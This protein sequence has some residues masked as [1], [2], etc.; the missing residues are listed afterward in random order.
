[1]PMQPPMTQES[2]SSPTKHQAP[3]C[4]FCGRELARVTRGQYGFWAPCDCPDAQ[5]HDKV[6][7]AE[8]ERAIAAE[9]EEAR[10][11]R[12]RKA[13]IP[14]RWYVEL[15]N[16]SLHAATGSRYDPG[17]LS[18][19]NAAM[20]GQG[21]WLIG[22]VGLGKTRAAM[23][24]AMA[25]M[26]QRTISVG[27]GLSRVEVTMAKVRCITEEDILAAAGSRFG[28]GST[29]EAALAGFKECALLILDDLGKAK[30]TAWAVSQ[31]FAVIDARYSS[32]LPLVV[33]SQY[34]PSD[35]LARLSE[36]GEA[37]TAK[38]LGSRLC[39]MCDRKQ[40]Q[41][42]DHRLAG[43]AHVAGD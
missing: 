9:L 24:A 22:D 18:I 17:A 5:A 13:G 8:E 29:D 25:Y 31:I 33:T 15:R 35:L 39:P 16:P 30:P 14:E 27:Q 42:Y 11:R 37:K 1:M 7:K 36:E 4:P 23:G 38:S 43:D 2:A 40:M 26:D 41:G 6:R 12:Y 19:C 20:R 28:K 3:L 34:G 32:R 21:T 10:L